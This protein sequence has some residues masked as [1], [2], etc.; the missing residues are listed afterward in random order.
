M[1]H[2]KCAYGNGE[3]KK[4]CSSMYWNG[5][6]SLCGHNWFDHVNSNIKY[7][8]KMVKRPMVIEELRE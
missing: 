7:K 1:C 6:C 8:Y 2:I 3:D 4:K 5:L